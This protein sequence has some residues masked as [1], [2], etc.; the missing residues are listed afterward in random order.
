MFLFRPYWNMFQQL[1]SST[2]DVSIQVLLVRRILREMNTDISSTSFW[3]S[4]IIWCSFQNLKKPQ[5]NQF[6]ALCVVQVRGFLVSYSKSFRYFRSWLPVWYYQTK[7]LAV[8]NE[9]NIKSCVG[10]DIFFFEVI[11]ALT[12]KCVYEGF[13]KQA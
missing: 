10:G 11:Q 6:C 9:E 3:P 1:R 7:S 13:A 4:E 5:S 8:S 2:N 12:K